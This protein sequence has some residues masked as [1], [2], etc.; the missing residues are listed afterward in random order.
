MQRTLAYTQINNDSMDRV[1]PL[2]CPIREKEWLDGWDC[3]MI[4][5]HSGLIEQD[6]VFTTV[7]HGNQETIWYVTQYDHQRNSIEFLRVTPHENIVKINI[8]CEGI[9]EKQTKVQ[10]TYQYS[11]LSS[12]QNSYIETDLEKDF[13]SSM[14]WWEKAINHYLSTGLMLKR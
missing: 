11:G 8:L 3:K 2:L 14:I 4:H 7:Q 13:E 10:I 12:D 9:G 1:F 5:S 6:C